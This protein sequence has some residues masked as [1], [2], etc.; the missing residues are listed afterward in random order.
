MRVRRESTGGTSVCSS[1]QADACP[2]PSLT[3][4]RNA[5]SPHPRHQPITLVVIGA[6]RIGTRSAFLICGN[7]RP[8]SGNSRILPAWTLPSVALPSRNSK[9]LL[10]N[11]GASGAPH[12]PSSLLPAT[13]R[14]DVAHRTISG[15]FHAFRMFEPN[16]GQMITK[17]LAHAK[18]LDYISTDAD[19]MCFCHL[20]P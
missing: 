16:D 18:G 12:R 1:G 3:F 4:S 6:N 13:S 19:P 20:Y 14:L 10:G 11:R 8:C 9:T 7:S 17:P 2:S 15:R 5:T